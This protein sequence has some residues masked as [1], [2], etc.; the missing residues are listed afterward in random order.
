MHVL[1][2]IGSSHTYAQHSSHS[3]SLYIDWP[4]F[5]SHNL[6]LQY[7]FGGGGVFGRAAS[8]LPTASKAALLCPSD[9]G[10][11]GGGLQSRSHGYWYRRQIGREDSRRAPAP[12]QAVSRARTLRSFPS[13]SSRS[14]GT[15]A[16]SA[17]ARARKGRPLQGEGG[18]GGGSVRYPAPILKSP[19][20][21]RAS[22]PPLGGGGGWHKTSVSDC[23]PLAAPWG[24]GG[25]PQIC[26][27]V[28]Q[29][30]SASAPC[31][32]FFGAFG[33]EYFLCFL[34][35]GDG[36]PPWGGGQSMGPT[37]WAGGRPVVLLSN[38]HAR[39]VPAM[40]MPSLR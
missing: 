34:G 16:L 40:Q 39:S 37:G 33:A 12:L 1:V 27:I 17:G 3:G 5:G 28:S 10:C 11:D 6:W 7:G 13:V 31:K 30:K 38:T 4:C 23:L 29:C 18:C 21:C 35:Q 25:A 26:T 20:F 15:A 14:V 2:C 24:G 19:P 36:S 22:S 8:F 32:I 9:P